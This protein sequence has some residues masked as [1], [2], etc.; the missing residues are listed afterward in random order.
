VSLEAHPSAL[1]A[2]IM[3]RSE[4][5]AR[6]IASHVRPSCRV[7]LQVPFASTQ[8]EAA[9][10]PSTRGQTFACQDHAEGHPTTRRRAAHCAHVVPRT[11]VFWPSSHDG[12]VQGGFTPEPRPCA[13]Q[14]PRP[15]L[16]NAAARSCRRATPPCLGVERRRHAVCLLASLRAVRVVSAGTCMHACVRTMCGSRTGGWSLPCV[17]SD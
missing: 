10:H 16:L 7:C 13:P 9:V 8:E 17:M 5:R 12:F 1:W 11:S 15:R 6:L 4:P 14:R 3:S 2:T